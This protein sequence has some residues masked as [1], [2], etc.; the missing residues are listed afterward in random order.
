MERL[1]LFKHMELLQL[2]IN[3]T[4]IINSLFIM[5]FLFS[6]ILKLREI[7]DQKC[8]FPRQVVLPPTYDNLFKIISIHNEQI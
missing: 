4:Y 5:Y 3:I 2:V 6:R 1:Y 8:E 7:E